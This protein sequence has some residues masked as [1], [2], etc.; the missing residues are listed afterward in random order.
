MRRRWSS[1]EAAS[2][3]AR[4]SGEYYLEIPDGGAVVK[5]RPHGSGALVSQWWSGG[6]MEELQGGGGTVA[7]AG[8]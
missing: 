2:R 4:S 6:I 1:G 8:R 7:K 5:W 3:R